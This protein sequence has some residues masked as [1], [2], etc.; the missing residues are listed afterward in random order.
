MEIDDESPIP[1]HL[2]LMSKP[3]TGEF[4]QS[5]RLPEKLIGEGAGY[6]SDFS[7]VRQ[8]R[9]FS[10]QY[11]HTYFIRLSSIRPILEEKIRQQWPD[12]P[13]K[14]IA[15][16]CESSSMTVTSPK[17][18]HNSP[19]KYTVSS[20]RKYDAHS[21]YGQ[22]VEHGQHIALREDVTVGKFSVSLFHDDNQRGKTYTKWVCKN[23]CIF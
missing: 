1:L 9:Q 3:G 18:G 7:S 2:D 16:L 4:P 10:Y 22:D 21:S 5:T 13:L 15:G 19:K 23:Y 14:K 6:A 12:V 11:A 8:G 17:K 20:P